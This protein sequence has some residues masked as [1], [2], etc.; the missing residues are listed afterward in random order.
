MDGSFS[1]LFM[2][3]GPNQRKN[4]YIF[5][6]DPN[7]ILYKNILLEF[8]SLSNEWIFKVILFL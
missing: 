1:I 3:V 4:Q 8:Y 2:L 5:E 7:H 6:K